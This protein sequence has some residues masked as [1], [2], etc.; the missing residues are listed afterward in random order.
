[1]LETRPDDG[2]KDRLDM[3]KTVEEKVL[4]VDG[5]SNSKDA[6]E[7][8]RRRLDAATRHST[9][10]ESFDRTTKPDTIE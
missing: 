2:G 8:I 6:S 4:H 9:A 10:S 5:P 7:R 3:P 1:M